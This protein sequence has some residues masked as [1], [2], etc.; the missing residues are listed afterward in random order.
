MEQTFNPKV[1]G[2]QKNTADQI[3]DEI[4]AEITD[5]NIKNVKFK[6]VN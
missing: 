2:P 5:H 6:T 4:G 3:L 1:G